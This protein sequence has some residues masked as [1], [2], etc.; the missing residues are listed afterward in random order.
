MPRK[1][2]VRKSRQ[3]SHAAPPVLAATALAPTAHVRARRPP[4]YIQCLERTGR[5]AGWQVDG[6]YVRK[7]IDN[8]LGA[9]GHHYSFSAIPRN[10]I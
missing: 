7:Q 4:P 2:A 10:E 1:R 3:S 5:V 8:E 9:F 6:A